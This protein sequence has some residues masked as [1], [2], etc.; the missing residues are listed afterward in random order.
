MRASSM[1][2]VLALLVAGCAVQPWQQTKLTQSTYNNEDYDYGLAP[3]SR[4]RIGN[5][6]APTPTAIHGAKTIMTP[7][8]RDMMT[9]PNPPLLIYVLDVDQTVSLPG[10]IWLP[11]TGLGNR[12][13]QQELAS[14]LT[15]LTGGDKLKAIVFFCLS[16][17]CWLS[18]NAA[19]R[20]VNLGYTR[21]YWYRGGRN[22]WKAAGLQMKPVHGLSF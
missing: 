17:T 8:L 21:V 19:V 1:L 15:K 18:H 4:I 10:A 12:N 11:G 20:A 9:G 14:D 3:T 5:Y 6:E 7:E 22:A 2:V 13:A 16:E